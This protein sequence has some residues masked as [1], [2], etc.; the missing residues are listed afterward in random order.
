MSGEDGVRFMALS[1]VVDYTQTVSMPLP[2]PA[3]V[4]V[5]GT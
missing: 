4:G 5:A 2:A 1:I 3:T